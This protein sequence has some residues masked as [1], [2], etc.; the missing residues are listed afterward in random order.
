MPR[1]YSDVTEQSVARISKVA[2]MHKLVADG[3]TDKKV[4]SWMDN[5]REGD[6]DM[7]WTG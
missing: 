1:I 4:V 2:V 5:P 6:S 3:T 7:P